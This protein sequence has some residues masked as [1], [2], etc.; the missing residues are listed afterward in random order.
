MVDER[1]TL[2]G[3]TINPRKP[4]PLA[5]I[6]PTAAR[7]LL[8]REGLVEGEVRTNAAFFRKNEALLRRIGDQVAKTRDK[9]WIVDEHTQ[10]RFYDERLPPDIVN[11]FTLHQWIKD[12]QNHSRLLMTQIDLIHDAQSEFEQA[13]FPDAVSVGSMELGVSYRYSPGEESDGLTLEIPKEGLGR[14]S[15]RQLG[16]LVPG[17]LE[18]KVLSL[19]R[20]LPKS[21]RRNFVPAPDVAKQITG[22]LTFGQGDV[23]EQLATRLS[24]Y[25]GEPIRVSDFQEERL[26]GY[27][28]FNVRVVDAD[29]QSL[30][31]GRQVERL[32][33]EVGVEATQIAAPPTRNKEWDRAGI[34]SWDFGELPTEVKLPVAGVEVPFFPTLLDQGD[35]VALC[36]M[37]SRERSDLE[38]RAGLRR[39]FAIAENREI[40]SQVSWLPG[41][42]KLLVYAATLGS[43]ASLKSQLGDLIADRA[44]FIQPGFPRDEAAFD[45]QRKMGR[46]EITLATQSVLKVVKPLFAAYHGAQLAYESASNPKWDHAVED[47]ALHLD[48]LTKGRFLVETP[49]EW[50]L[51]LP[52]FFKAVSVRFDK[53]ASAGFARDQKLHDELRLHLDRWWEIKDDIHLSSP[54]LTTYRWMLEEFRVSLF[55]QEL[56]TSQTVSAKRMEKHWKK[57]L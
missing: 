41:L 56:G 15:S 7:E 49:W 27:L 40:K 5:P 13:Q 34:K 4:V 16:W 6:D 1:V 51:H 43:S 12:K 52:R 2:F 25:A 45:E 39:L 53:L 14:I 29:G 17:L 50:L 35:S 48:E 20:S 19:I 11:L 18:E 24:K 23:L 46:R 54:A 30:A 55:A 37:D 8:I 33:D 21:L 42:D 3:L 36:L 47:T 26:P 57:C 10:Y 32:Q 9:K 31:E 28:R 38:T 44:F 22:D